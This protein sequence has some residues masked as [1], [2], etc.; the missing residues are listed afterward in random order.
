MHYTDLKSFCL[1]RSSPK[2]LAQLRFVIAAGISTAAGGGLGYKVVISSHLQP[3]GKGWLVLRVFRLQD[4]VACSIGGVIVFIYLISSPRNNEGLPSPR[5]QRKSITRL[6]L[7]IVLL[8]LFL[9]S[10]LPSSIMAIQDLTAIGPALTAAK[11]LL[12]LVVLSGIL[13]AHVVYQRFFHP[14]A[15]VPGPFLASISRLWITRESYRGD[16]HRTLISLHNRHGRLVRIAPNELSV[17]DPTAIKT[18]YGAGSKFE[19]SKWYSVW[20]GHRKLDLFGERDEKIH[21]QQ[22]RLVSRPYSMDSLKDLEPYVDNTVQAF[23]DAMSQRA[24][25]VVDMGNWL[26]LFAFGK[27]ISTSGSSHVTC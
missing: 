22:R 14:L 17:S 18:I 7:T 4:G 1:F 8:S 27:S 25:Q 13:L 12:L 24:G 21:G 19:K 5:A 6:Q 2:H 10:H 3:G 23:L 26:Q 11:V 9:M 16:Y 20:Q 15:Q